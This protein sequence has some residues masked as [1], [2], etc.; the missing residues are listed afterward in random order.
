MHVFGP[1]WK[2]RE[3]QITQ[4]PHRKIG[5][6]QEPSWICL[7][8]YGS[9]SK[10]DNISTTWRFSCSCQKDQSLHVWISYFQITNLHQKPVTNRLKPDPLTLWFWFHKH[11]MTQRGFIRGGNHRGCERGSDREERKEGGWKE[12]RKWDLLPRRLRWTIVGVRTG[13]AYDRHNVVK[14]QIGQCVGDELTML[15]WNKCVYQ[16]DFL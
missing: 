12:S 4:T 14:F 5:T 15:L 9:N 8:N 11:K 3:P 10:T 16:K 7:N 13:N 1:W 2:P 6:K